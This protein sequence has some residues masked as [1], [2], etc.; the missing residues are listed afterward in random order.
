MT[1]H[2]VQLVKDSWALV[3][4]ISQQAG[5]LFY[6]RLFDVAPQIKP[7]FKGNMAMQAKMLT[8]MITYVV[9]K[10]DKLEEIIGEIKALAVRHKGYGTKP[11]HYPVVGECLIWTLEKGLGTRWNKE[12]QDAWI[13][14]YTILSKTMIDAAK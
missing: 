9:N 5:D 11:E 4:P 3:I 8:E 12:L 10:L 2:Q 6:G 13:A 14:A 1:A 7:L